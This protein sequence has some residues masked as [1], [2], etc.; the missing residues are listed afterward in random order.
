MIN[1]IASRHAVASMLIN[2]L[3]R[4]TNGFMVQ[5][6]KDYEALGEIYAIGGYNWSDRKKDYLASRSCRRFPDKNPLQICMH[7]LA[8][9]STK[10]ALENVW[11]G[12]T[13]AVRYL[14]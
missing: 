8:F 9:T 11:M 1:P 6:Q 13:Q 14:L 5:Y 7:W 10:S 2:C 12:H 3:D 4:L